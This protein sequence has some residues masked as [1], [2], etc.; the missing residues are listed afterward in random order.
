MTR[1]FFH[2]LAVALASIAPIGVQNLFVI[3]SAASLPLGHALAT[4]AAV[5]VFD[6]SLTLGAFF[7]VGSLLAAVPALR[8]AVLLAGGAVVVKIG[9]GLLFAECGELSREARVFNVRKTV[10]TAFAVTWLNPQALV[11]TTLFFGAFRASLPHADV[12][13]FVCGCLTASPLWFVCITLAVSTLRSRLGPGFLR[14]L[15]VGCGAFVTFC[16]A[17]LLW[18]FAGAF[19]R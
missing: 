3:N 11:D 16:G 15:N 8:G 2:G 1:V 13:P 18:N 19:L 17:R 5:F 12:P 4:A 9:V 6:M 10:A 7:G 14:A